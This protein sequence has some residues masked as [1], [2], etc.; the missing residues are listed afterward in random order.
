MLYAVVTTALNYLF[1]F[2]SAAGVNKCHLLTFG[3]ADSN[4]LQRQVIDPV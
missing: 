2:Y 4:G 3:T 1:L